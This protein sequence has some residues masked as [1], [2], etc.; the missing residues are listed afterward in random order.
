MNYPHLDINHFVNR[1]HDYYRCILIDGRIF[2]KV[3]DVD[4]FYKAIGYTEKWIDNGFVFEEYY[5]YT[6][7]S[8]Y[9]TKHQE[10]IPFL[11]MTYL[12]EVS[13]EFREKYGSEFKELAGKCNFKKKLPKYP[14]LTCMHFSWF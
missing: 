9:A 7:R 2:H 14:C 12:N 13:S 10:C 3:V 6:F 4:R 5:W 11:L 1:Y 8:P